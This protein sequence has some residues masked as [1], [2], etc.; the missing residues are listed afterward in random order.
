M[1]RRLPT[2]KG[3]WSEVWG[4]GKGRIWDGASGGRDAGPDAGGGREE[5]EGSQGWTQTPAGLGGSKNKARFQLGDALQ[6]LRPREA[7]AGERT[8]PLSHVGLFPSRLRSLTPR[9]SPA[10]PTPCG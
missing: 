9:L 7:A 1:D 2:R 6:Q 4:R 5:R 8:P 10:T 3:R